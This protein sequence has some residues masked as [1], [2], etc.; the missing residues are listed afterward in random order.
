[1]LM[2]REVMAPEL[3]GTSSSNG[4]KLAWPG[5]ISTVTGVPSATE[6]MPCSMSKYRE[7]AGGAKVVYGP[8]TKRKSTSK[9]TPRPF[10]ESPMCLP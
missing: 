6:S 2:S 1:M 5:R 3:V 7:G 9:A 10:G 8:M 4:V